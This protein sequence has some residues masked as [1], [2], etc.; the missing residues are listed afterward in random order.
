M[1]MKIR[2]NKLK[3][4]KRSINRRKNLFKKILKL[5]YKKRFRK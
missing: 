2:Y 5:K 1:K 4:S 3:N